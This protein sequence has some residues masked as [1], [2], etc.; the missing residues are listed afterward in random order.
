MSM[1]SGANPPD[2]IETTSHSHSPKLNP[3]ASFDYDQQIDSYEKDCRELGIIEEQRKLI[4]HK[5]HIVIM[6]SKDPTRIAKIL[7]QKLGAG[8]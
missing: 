3:F 8:F 7:K 5:H 1:N 6:C 2:L 4:T